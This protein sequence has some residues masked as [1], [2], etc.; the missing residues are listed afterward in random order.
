M[1]G[2]YLTTTGSYNPEAI[3][4][5]SNSL[6]L[7]YNGK[8]MKVMNEY[9]FDFQRLSDDYD[10]SESVDSSTITALSIHGSQLMYADLLGH[11]DDVSSYV[12]DTSSRLASYVVTNDARVA[13]VSS[14]TEN[15]SS[16][17]AT[18]ITNN[19]A[20]VANVSTYAINVSTH[21]NEVSTRLSTANTN[22]ST[23]VTRVANVSTYAIN[24]S[25]HANEVS[26]RLA[27]TDSSVRK[28]DT[29]ALSFDASIRETYANLIELTN[30]WAAAWNEMNTRVADISSRIPT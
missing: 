12:A 22:I 21:V 25:T 4:D 16:R 8:S 26:T 23:L 27:N 24:V 28:L 30:V 11:I 6:I 29:S 15:T 14:Y 3:E 13:N 19:D 5:I 9:V 10:A 17:L 7:D 20:R 18:Y 1:I 2:F